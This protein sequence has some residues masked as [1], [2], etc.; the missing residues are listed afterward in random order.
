[1]IFGTQNPKKFNV[2][3]FYQYQR[4]VSTCKDVSLNFTDNV[5]FKFVYPCW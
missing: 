3:D 4:M 5:I 1:M 2:S